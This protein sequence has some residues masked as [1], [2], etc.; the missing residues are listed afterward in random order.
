MKIVA[1]R[2]CLLSAMSSIWE[3]VPARSPKPIL[4]NAKIVADV[5]GT[6]ILATDL[7][8]GVTRNVAGVEIVRPG[9]AILSSRILAS[10]K[11]SPDEDITIES[12]E[13]FVHVKT[14]SS[15]YK[16]TSE[17]PDL[18]PSVPDFDAS[19]YHTVAPADLKDGINRTVFAVDPDSTKYALGG[20][21]WA[22]GPDA[23]LTLAATDGRRMAECNIPLGA[24]GSPPDYLNGG[25]EGQPAPVVP[26]RAA[27]FIAK[28]IN[29]DGLS[30]D[31]SVHALN[32]IVVRTEDAVIWS[33]LVEGRFPRYQ[34]VFPGSHEHKLSMRAAALLG[35]IRQ[36]AIATSDESRGIDFAFT[37]EGLT[38]KGVASD[39]GDATVEVPNPD[40]ACPAEGI[41]LSFDPQYLVGM[42]RCLPDEAMVEM[43]L[44][45]DGR[46]CVFIYNGS[47]SYAVSPLTRKK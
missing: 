38:L 27:K 11:A 41:N 24:V 37:P 6:R 26:E 17:N 46:P 21:L 2:E 31:I 42:L 43:E 18:F 15:K 40:P 16:F 23:S 35:G 1:N 3:V 25:K 29:P 9:S 32:S 19:D 39:V 4:M 12:D 30:V 7:Q 34:D 33:R 5:D 8:I 44:I 47:Y 28:T 14:K 13:K 20:I 45:S 10:V 36:A 22:L